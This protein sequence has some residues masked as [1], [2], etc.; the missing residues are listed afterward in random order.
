MVTILTE[1]NDKEIQANGGYTRK[2]FM[3]FHSFQRQKIVFLVFILYLLLF[4][5]LSYQIVDDSL[6][7]VLLLFGIPIVI[8]ASI[9][10]FLFVIVEKFKNR[11]EYDYQTFHSWH[12]TINKEKIIQHFSDSYRID[13]DWNDIQKGYEIYGMFF[14]YVTKKH[15][16]ILPIRNFYSKSDYL[17]FKKYAKK[18]KK[19]K[20]KK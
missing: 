6:I 9:S 1:A 13:I 4:L 10:T 2:E 18:N 5:L 7:I 11:L 15:I 8:L 3:I 16:I 14:L 20:L 17:E 19:I 12:F